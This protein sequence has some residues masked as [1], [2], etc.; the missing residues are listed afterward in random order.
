MDRMLMAE[1]A[2]ALA[3]EVEGGAGDQDLVIDLQ[4]IAA[5]LRG[6][7]A[8]DLREDSTASI[9]ERHRLFGPSLNEV[10]R[11]A[12]ITAVG[13][14][15]NWLNN[16]AAHRAIPEDARQ[17]MLQVRDE[18]DAALRMPHTR[19]FARSTR[20]AHPYPQFTCGHDT[21]PDQFGRCAVYTHEEGYCMGRLIVEGEGAS[22]R[23]LH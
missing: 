13:H 6:E 12:L 3:A 2:A 5:R 10:Q 11:E 22:E 8:V 21:V 19:G 9:A 18:C 4:R 7:T 15:G 16:Y 1:R 23:A 14:A 17:I 20:H